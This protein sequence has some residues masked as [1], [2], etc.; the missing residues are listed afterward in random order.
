MNWTHYKKSTMTFSTCWTVW[1]LNLPF[2][3]TLTLTRYKTGKLDKYPEMKFNY[4]DKK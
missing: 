4:E 1:K 3:F 2:G